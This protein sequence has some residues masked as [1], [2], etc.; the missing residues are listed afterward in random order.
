[1]VN[2]PQLNG[3]LVIGGGI[4]GVQAALDLAEAGRK[5]YLVE[6]APAIGGYMAMLDKT[7]PTNDCSMCILSPKL[8]S[9]ARH[10]N[11]EL[12]TL[13][14]VVATAG[15]PGNFLVKVRRY[16]RSVDLSRC[17]GCGDCLEKCPVKV[18]SEFEG[19]L[20]QRRAIYRLYAQAVPNAPVIDRQHC[21]KFTKDR[22]GNCA[23]V[24]KAG[25]IDYRQDDEEIEIRVGAII[26]AA[27]SK[28]FNPAVRPEF[29]Y[30]RLANVVTALE[31]ER[32]LSAS[33][34]YGGRVKRPGDGAEPKKI[35]WVQ[36]FGSRDETIGSSYC[37]SVCC[38]YAAKEAV[39]AREHN[40]DIEPTVF[41]MDM[42]AYGKEFDRYIE[43]AERQ[44]GVRF[45]RAR[46]AEILE[47]RLTGR[48]IVR[49]AG[50]NGQQ[51]EGFDLVVLSCGLVPEP[52]TGLTVE[53]NRFGFPLTDLIEPVNASRRGIFIAGSCA[54]PVAIPETVTAASAAAVK[55]LPL[56]VP[57][58]RR[59]QPEA[60][61]KEINVAG[62]APR[63]GVFVCNCGINIGGVVRVPEVVEYART[64]P[65]VVFVEENLYSCSADTLEKIKSRIKEQNLNRVVVA[66]C[67]PRTHEPLFQATLSE[68]G[69]NPHLLAMANIRD[70]CSWVH[71]DRDQATVK[72][73]D[74]VK[75]AVAR[76]RRQQP[77]APVR[78][79]VTKAGLVVGGGIAGLA[80]A[81]ALA[82][83]GVDV[84]LIEREAVLGG[85]ARQIYRTIEGEDVQQR[86]NSLIEQV[87]NHPRIRVYT[88][89]EIRRVDGFVGSFETTIAVAGR[90]ERFRHG[91]VIVAVGAQYRQPTEYQ[92]GSDPRVRTQ[93]ELEEIIA[94]RPDELHNLHSVVMIQCVGSREGE[95]NYCSRICCAEAIK[96]ALAIKNLNPDCEV[97]ILYRD[98]R[99][100]GFREEYYRQ[101]RELGVIFI[102]YEVERKPQVQVADNGLTVQVHEPVLGL[103]LTLKPDLLVLSTGV[104]PQPDAERL[105]Q[106]LKVPRQQ[107]GF[108]LEAHAKL[109]PVDFATEGVFLAG[110]CHYPEFIDETIAS[111]Q[112]A[113]GRAATV[114]ARDFIEAEP[115]QAVV[116]PERCSAC[117]MCAGLCAYRAIEVR[118]VEERTG[119]RAAVVNQAMCK[120][121]G[122]CAANCRSEAI[123]IRGFAA[124]NIC[125]E[126]ATLF[127]ES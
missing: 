8:V 105:A 121:C 73:K 95:R 60:S 15:E 23:R 74:L 106:M 88:G 13:S 19:G 79:P 4:G 113:A 17:T 120:G 52:A 115:Y 28:I 89:A 104:E 2:E 45:V 112:A 110:L 11:I 55:A 108:F 114:L 109:R 63:I 93:Q 103:P 53:H 35:A 102:R 31:F 126:I 117:G 99:T 98:I 33:G 59:F 118:V 44:Y 61:Q 119:K 71:P 24:C 77:L 94:R 46:V 69:L 76:V 54:Q 78:L 21:L 43:R 30:K 22:C 1:M 49:Y 32:I 64:L 90:E 75:M 96:N 10:P 111:A 83:S 20:A 68:A 40:P 42:R 91:V 9:C 86:L 5:V 41:Y 65:G 3:V 16:A 25:A 101:A 48:L 62:I 70:Q 34:P 82:D 51:A 127:S 87:T 7:F 97:F 123:D 50:D 72:A 107:D 6:R 14:E 100:Y 80:A 27:G 85:V 12:L 18:P 66:S 56:T 81:R 29:G 36:C 92:F 84:L 58:S 39:I 67:S 122:A 38:M 124:E 37:S 125:R 26:I 116:S 47:D 57:A